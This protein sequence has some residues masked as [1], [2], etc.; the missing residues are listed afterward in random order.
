MIFMPAAH[1]HI[2]SRRTENWEVNR[3]CEDVRFRVPGYR[4]NAQTPYRSPGAAITAGRTMESDYW[5]TL[6]ACPEAKTPSSQTDAESNTLSSK[7]GRVATVNSECHE[8]H[9]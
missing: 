3:K 5:T 2:L 1:Q 6:E 9:D 4:T 8:F 7:A